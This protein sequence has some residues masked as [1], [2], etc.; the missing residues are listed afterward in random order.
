MQV[1]Q[2]M[3]NAVLSRYDAQRA[4]RTAQMEVGPSFRVSADR[5]IPALIPKPFD[6]FHKKAESNFTPGS[7]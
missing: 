2:L 6:S 5:A 3:P 4:R 1:K 7:P